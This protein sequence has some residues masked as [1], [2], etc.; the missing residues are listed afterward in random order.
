MFK[1]IL[2]PLDGSTYA[3]QALPVASTLAHVAGGSLLL[4]GVCTLETSKTA[5]AEFADYLAH[6]ASSDMLKDVGAVVHLAEGTPA[7]AILSV[8]EA[9]QID[10]LV[11]SSHRHTGLTHWIPSSV[12]QKVVRHSPVPILIMREEEGHV[13][14]PSGLPSRPARV[15]VALDGSP[16]AEEV[17]APAVSL[18]AALAAPR[19]GELHLVRVVHLPVMYEYGQDDALAKAKR[20]G[21]QEAQ[22]YLHTIEQRLQM[23]DL[24]S[25][26]LLVTSSV[27]MSMDIAGTLL[28]LAKEDM[29][30]GCVIALATHGHSGFKRWIVGSVAERL[31]ETATLPLLVVSPGE[32]REMK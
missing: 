6:L 26:Q 17:L 18:S 19:A 14:I 22:S 20:Q 13:H 3:E 27:A 29:Q 32:V 23:E 5:R 16:L 30:Q 15:M 21:L 10:F 7:E 12:A 31:L 25:K 2:V 11:M 28:Q 1:R 9:W 4:V 24:S 8:L